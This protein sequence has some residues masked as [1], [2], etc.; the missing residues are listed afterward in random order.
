VLIH[1]CHRATALR[2]AA[3]Q[4]APKLAFDPNLTVW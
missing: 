2:P 1:V 3:G 4:L